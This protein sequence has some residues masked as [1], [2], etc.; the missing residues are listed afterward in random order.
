[1]DDVRFCAM[2]A[3]KNTWGCLLADDDSS[4]SCICFAL[5]ASLPI[6]QKK[7]QVSSVKWS[8]GLLSKAHDVCGAYQGIRYLAENGSFGK[9][10]ISHGSLDA[11][12][13]IN[14]NLSRRARHL[15]ME[16]QFPENWGEKK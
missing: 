4:D 10:Q 9:A 14:R 8:A 12:V 2:S 16:T 15:H 13:Y 5:S 7:F 3:D 1:M 6:P 11:F